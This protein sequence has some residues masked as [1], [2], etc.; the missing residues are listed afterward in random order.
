MEEK[1]KCNAGSRESMWG[2]GRGEMKGGGEAFK[3]NEGNELFQCGEVG[4][5]PLNL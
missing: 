1:Q 4:K 2:P 3:Q 5:T